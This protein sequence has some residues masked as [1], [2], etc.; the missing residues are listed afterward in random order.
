[1]VVVQ[2]LAGVFAPELSVAVGRG[3]AQ[4]GGEDFGSVFVEGGLA[5]GVVG[6]EGDEA[7]EVV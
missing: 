3:P 7:G 4:A 1:M 6:E 5:G 2:D